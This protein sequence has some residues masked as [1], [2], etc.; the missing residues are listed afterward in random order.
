MGI[1]TT[2]GIWRAIRADKILKAAEAAQPGW[3]ERL[4]RWTGF[5]TGPTQ[6][7]LLTTQAHWVGLSSAC[8]FGKALYDGYQVWSTSKMVNLCREAAHLIRQIWLIAAETYTFSKFT[9]I[10]EDG[11]HYFVDTEAQEIWKEILARKL[12]KEP[13]ESDTQPQFVAEYLENRK[14]EVNGVRARLSKVI[15][16]VYK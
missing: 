10:N 1:N 12:D 14:N 4:G 16:E 7:E 15:E 9:A 5:V 8:F 6:K 13:P 3:W 11:R 2:F